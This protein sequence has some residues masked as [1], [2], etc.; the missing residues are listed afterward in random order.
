VWRQGKWDRADEGGGVIS[1][2]EEQRRGSQG[3]G[4]GERE[5]TLT[6]ERD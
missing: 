2:A 5:E 1:L 6:R 4:L 3:R